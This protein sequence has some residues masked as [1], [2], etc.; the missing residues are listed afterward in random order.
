MKITRT[1]KWT[2][3][4]SADDRQTLRDTVTLYQRYVRAVSSVCMVHWPTVGVLNGN[5][6][7]KVVEG[8][9][10]PTTKRPSVKYR[11]FQNRFYKFPS[12]LR[13]SAIMDAVGQVRSFLSRYDQWQTATDRRH[14]HERP[15]TFGVS[16]SFPSLY[17]GQCIKYA[18]DLSAA[19]I[20]V[21]KHGDWVWQTVPIKKTGKRAAD[22]RQKRAS[23]LLVVTDKQASL[24]VPFEQTVTLGPKN[25][26]VVCAVDLG[27]NTSITASVVRSDGTVLG[28]RF[29]RRP[30]DIDRLHTRLALIRR[31]ARK[32]KRMSR[33]FAAKWHRKGFNIA[34]DSAHQM[35]R[36]LVEFA[37]SLGATTLVFENLKGWRPKAPRYGL[38]KKFHTWLHRRIVE[39]AQ[40]KWREHSGRMAFVS[41]RGTSKYA[42]DGSG[43]VTR[44]VNGNYSVCRFKNGKVYNCDLNATYNIAAKFFLIG[45]EAD[46]LAPGQ[47]PGAKPRIPATLSL[48]WTAPALQSAA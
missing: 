42:F 19:E 39:F 47:S 6:V 2:L 30:S 16:N 5:E 48:L 14:K 41:A 29:I 12:Y 35:T 22:V 38:R 43:E 34:R 23:P 37:A 10:H 11:Y 40:W 45:R 44:S 15:P 46:Q 1:E 27:I 24:A 26:E 25:A 32:T 7:I 33:G 13:R 3:R 21:F 20:K 9:I 28:R 8:L 18:D 31:A 4:P 17:K 36:E